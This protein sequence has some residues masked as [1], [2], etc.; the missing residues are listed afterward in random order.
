MTESLS[1]AVKGELHARRLEFGDKIKV[2]NNKHF[3][4]E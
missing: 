2:R 3:W 1:A 4:E